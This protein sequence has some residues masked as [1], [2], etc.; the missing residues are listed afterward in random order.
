MAGAGDG[1]RPGHR[2][3]AVQRVPGLELRGFFR[4]DVREAEDPGY[5]VVGLPPEMPGMLWR[6]I[7]AGMWRQAEAG[8][9]DIHDLWE[10]N[11]ALDVMEENR[12]R[13]ARAAEKKG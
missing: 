12:R 10:I 1:V 11:R 3:R 7:L 6:P 8:V 4:E 13:A 2:K 5:D 9:Y